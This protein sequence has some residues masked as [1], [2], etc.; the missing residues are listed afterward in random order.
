MF[1]FAAAAAVLLLSLAF[2]AGL[3]LCRQINGMVSGSTHR[4]PLEWA[5]S[6]KHIIFG[7]Q[8][9]QYTPRCAL[10]PSGNAEETFLFFLHKKSTPGGLAMYKHTRAPT[11]HSLACRVHSST[12]WGKKNAPTS[13]VLLMA[14]TTSHIM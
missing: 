1:V 2:W 10:V 4:R 9:P 11:S 3:H 14:S 13:G 12:V 6:V 7:L 8:T 5:H